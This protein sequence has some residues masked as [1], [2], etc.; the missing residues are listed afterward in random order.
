[1]KILK[2]NY[3][4]ITL[5]DE[6]VSIPE[7]Y[8]TYRKP[9]LFSKS[10][11]I[12]FELDGEGVHGWGEPISLREKDWRKLQDYKSINLE[13]YVLNSAVTEGYDEEL[14]I[15]DLIRQGLNYCRI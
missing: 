5:T 6:V 12:A 8:A 2:A 1:M 10:H 11:Q 14:I 3:H 4:I 7:G 13:H 15:K 9:D